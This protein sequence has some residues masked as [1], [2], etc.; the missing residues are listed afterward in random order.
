MPLNR[1]QTRWHFH[2]RNNRKVAQNFERLRLIAAQSQTKAEI[3]D[4]LHPWGQSINLRYHNGISILL[5]LIGVTLILLSTLMFFQSIWLMLS[6][7]CLAAIIFAYGYFSFESQDEMSI[8]VQQ[9]S[10]VIFY[11]Q[12]H[13]QMHT[14]PHLDRIHGLNDQYMLIKIRQA[15]DCLNLGNVSNQILNYAATHWQ[16]D[17]I[18]YP[19][20]LLHYLQT[21]EIIQEQND[22]RMLR[23]IKTYY[24]GACI[25]QLPAHGLAVST[26]KTDFPDYPVRWSSSDI[27][28]NQRYHISGQSE[29]HLAKTLTPQR[30]LS[31]AQH[32]KTMQGT[33]M[34]H[35]EMQACC[36]LSTQNIFKTQALKKPITDV[37]QLRGYLRTLQAPDYEN[38]QQQ[39]TAII[40]SFQDE[41][42]LKS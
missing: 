19:V 37:S 7:W 28:F 25:F 21:D 27:G 12:Y 13:I 26:H 35:P 29:L 3:L 39:L 40:R 18:H 31:L 23:T 17:G 20:L 33:L 41:S 24:W 36:Y 38:M 34:F 4:A 9:L 32:L 11:S 10:N 15:F 2:Q 1:L 6:L 22:Q 8:V 14:L 42:L 16:I 5:M 30:I